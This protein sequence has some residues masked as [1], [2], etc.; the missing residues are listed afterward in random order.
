MKGDTIDI[1]APPERVWPHVV[2]LARMREW[3][4]KLVSAEPVTSGQPRV[5]STWKTVSRMGRRERR[6]LSRIEVC[7]P[8]TRVVFVHQ[9]DAKRDRFARETIELT[10]HGACTRI[11]QS[12]DLTQSGIALPW[13]LLVGFIARS[14]TPVG[15]SIFAELKRTLERR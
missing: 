3:H 1:D 11:V 7:E 2:D 4:P 9:D 14:G 12:L 15:P 5:G 10:P 6:F 13:R 8:F